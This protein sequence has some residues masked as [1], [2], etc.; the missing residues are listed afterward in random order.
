MSYSH[1]VSE[2]AFTELHFS[3]NARQTAQQPENLAGT[4]VS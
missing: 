2:Q 1:A 3:I 4:T